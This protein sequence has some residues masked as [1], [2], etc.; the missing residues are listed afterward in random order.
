[1]ATDESKLEPLRDLLSL[2]I[3]ESL[4]SW[5]ELHGRV[6]AEIHYRGRSQQAV[7]RALGLQAEEVVQILDQCEHKLHS[8][9]R[10]FRNVT[11]HELSPPPPRPRVL[12]ASC[13]CR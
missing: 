7:A 2:V 13:C 12:A 1:M 4:R 3:M 10:A 8:A 5:P 11:A 9:L 6:F